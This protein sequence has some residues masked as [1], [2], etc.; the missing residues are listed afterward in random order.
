[1][2]LQA[3]FKYQLDQGAKAISLPL[4]VEGQG[5]FCFD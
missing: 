4:F 2:M 5:C 1:M 3:S